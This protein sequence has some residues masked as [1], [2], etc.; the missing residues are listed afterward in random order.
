MKIMKTIIISALMLATA[1]G[2]SAAAQV[3]MEPNAEGAAPSGQE[4]FAQGKNA[5]FKGDLQQAISCL[6]KAVSGN[7]SN[8]RYRFY[9][10]KALRYAGRHDEAVSQ[11]EKVL[12]RSPDHVEAAQVL[13]ELYSQVKR[14]ADVIAVLEPLLK[15]R[16]DYPM[17]HML[18]EAY[19]RGNNLTKAR[20]YFEKAVKLNPKS[21]SDH[22]ELGNIY[23]SRNFFALAAKSYESALEL[24]SEGP[25]LHY[26]LGTAYFN[27]RNYFGR[28]TEKTIKSG[29]AGTISG[30]HY[31]IEPVSGKK[32]VFRCAPSRSAIYQISR[33]LADGI[34]DKPDIQILKAAIFM[35]VRRYAQAF[36][37]FKKIEATVPKDDKAL[38]Y[39]YYAQTAFGRGEYEHYLQI[40]GKAI[41][42]DPEAYKP[43]LVDAY[44]KVADRY[45]QD[46]QLQNYIHY[47]EMAVSENP[48]TAS[49]HYKLGDA[50]E[51]AQDYEKAV[52]HWRMVLDLEPQHPRKTKL[53]NK[54]AQRGTQ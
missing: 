53:L 48:Q 33:A 4:L 51:E 18:A 41:K 49:L 38:F 42:L 30:E 3:E 11:L 31:L 1:L 35:N 14:F 24:G 50:C 5:L 21:A 13:C 44:L 2:V 10:A 16:H 12:K 29:K 40:L 34:E 37:M 46:G 26:K 39:Y 47:L 54:I 32:D 15:Y 17:Y 8:T 52:A 22:H 36:A 28:V 19:Y 23:L 20:T 45:N 27:L 43:T 25:V 7:E 9:L 6:E